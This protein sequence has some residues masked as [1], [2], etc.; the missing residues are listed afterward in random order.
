MS[1]DRVREIAEL[2]LYVAGEHTLRLNVSQKNVPLDITGA[3]VTNIE[4]IKPDG[5][6]VTFAATIVSPATQGIIERIFTSADLDQEGNW[7]FWA[8]VTFADTTTIP[9]NPV[10]IPVY[11]PGQLGLT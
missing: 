6:T 4:A 2:R 5:S 7:T 1:L 9:G 8:E 11:T 3:T 10:V